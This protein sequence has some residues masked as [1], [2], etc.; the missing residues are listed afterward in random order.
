METRPNS[1]IRSSN[2]HIELESEIQPLLDRS[3]RRGYFHDY[4][5]ILSSR[6]LRLFSTIFLMTFT[7]MSLVSLYP[8]IA[9]TPPPFGL[10]YSTSTIGFHIAIRSALN[11]ATMF[12]ATPIQQ[13]IGI[14]R[15]YRLGM[16]CLGM[17]TACMWAMMGIRDT[18]VVPLP[19]LRAMYFLLWAA[20]GLTVREL[21]IAYC[22][23]WCMTLTFLFLSLCACDHSRISWIT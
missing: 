3:T 4:M 23:A 5:S 2:T 22:F 8:L 10:G 1:L 11:I 9:F 19:L 6:V 17:T 13:R 16:I 21:L 12:V 14:M 20:G 15:T 18:N 7:T